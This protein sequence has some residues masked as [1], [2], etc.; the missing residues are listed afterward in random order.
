MSYH[1]RI[2]EKVICETVFCSSDGLGW[3]SNWILDKS[4]DTKPDEVECGCLYIYT[5]KIIQ[6]TIGREF[7]LIES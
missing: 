1:I 7:T 2:Y 5:S 4:L 3:V 6:G